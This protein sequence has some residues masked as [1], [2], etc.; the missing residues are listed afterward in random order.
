MKSL[1]RAAQ[2]LTSLVLS[3]LRNHTHTC[4]LV[5]QGLKRITKCI[6]R[7]ILFLLHVMPKSLRQR[8]HIR[9]AITIH[10]LHHHKG[11]MS[12]CRIVMRRQY[13]ACARR[14]ARR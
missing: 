9:K 3:T 1:L 8:F 10:A 6:R 7:R 13:R 14:K 2:R 5:I 12:R 4:K 11:I